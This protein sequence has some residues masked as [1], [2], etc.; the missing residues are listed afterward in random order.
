MHELWGGYKL[1]VIGLTGP[2]G[3]GKTIWGLEVDCPENTVIWD[4]EKS[5]ESYE[6]IYPGL[7][8]KDMHDI[9]GEKFKGSY[10]PEN[11][12]IEW[13]SQIRALP[14]DKFTVGILDPASEI[15]AGLCDYVWNHPKEYGKT[16]N[17]FEKSSGIYWG[18]VKDLWKRHIMLLATKFTTFVFTV[19]LRQKY[20][21]NAPLTGVYEPKGK[22][23][24]SECASLYLWLE[25]APNSEIPSARILNKNRLCRRDPVSG[26]VRPILP[27]TL[28]DGTPNGLRTYLTTP[29]DYANLKPHEKFQKQEISDEDKLALRLATANA[30]KDAANAKRALAETI[31]GSDR[32]G[33]TTTPSGEMVLLRKQ[34]A[35]PGAGGTES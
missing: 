7:V 4:M 28:K 34:D 20:E 5:S 12:Y 27:P 33:M 18:V 23:T 14:K 31:Q 9:M 15:E 8:R 35:P 2:Y 26:K 29:A 19:H 16:T 3:S 10:T 32:V 21:G 24:L 1:P 6:I 22:D 11:T 30:E 13:L 17:Q 25:R